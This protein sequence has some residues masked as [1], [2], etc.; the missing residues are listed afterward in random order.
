MSAWLMRKTTLVALLVPV[1]GCFAATE[2]APEVTATEAEVTVVGAGATCAELGLGAQEFRIESPVSGDYLIDARNQLTFRYYDATQ[3]MF[4]YTNSSIRMKGV[5]VH[6]PDATTVWEL[7]DA[8]G[9]PSLFGK[10]ASG[11]L[12]TPDA[13]SFCFDYTLF[14][15]PNAYAKYDQT[16]T[17]SIAKTGL[18]G[19]LTLAADQTYF[20]PYT[21]TVTPTGPI[22]GGPSASGPVF[23]NNPTPYT[24]RI[25]AVSIDLGGI[26][27]TV[28]CPV[29]LPYTLPAFTTLECQFH[30]ALPDTS[31]RV[32]TV[33][34]ASDGVLP[35]TRSVETLSFADHTTSTNEIDACVKVL[36][37]R[38]PYGFLGTACA[39]QGTRTFTYLAP[40]G[41][42]AACGPFEV[43]NTARVVGLDTDTTGS[44]TWTVRGQ[45]PCAGGCTLTPGYWKTHSQLGPAPYDA[46]W[47]LVGGHTAPFFLSGKS[48]H[49]ALWTAPAG[50]AYW[51]LAHAYI[52]ARLNQ[53]NDASFTAASAAFAQ[54]TTLLTSYTPA[55]VGLLPGRSPVRAQFLSLAS[56]LDAYNNGVIGPGHCT[57]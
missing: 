27:G 52:A 50:N 4:F 36:D 47:A 51:Q 25:D 22:A 29:A 16:W 19:A 35:V 42:F 37:D 38:V 17:W 21:V 55:A 28:T 6:A 56:T 14:L 7:P 13:V 3:T 57:E 40:I 34:V 9:W 49:D 46:T 11:N 12:I 20:A 24:P 1:A 43:Q 41:P 33:E 44:A 2:D 26:A 48:Y 53:L 5:L 10:D 23:V 30:A 39:S 31:D 45:V 18:T 54:A 15:N 8:N 32:V